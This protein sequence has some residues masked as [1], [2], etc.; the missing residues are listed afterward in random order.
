M[1][2]G[3]GLPEHGA[4]VEDDLDV[5]GR[6]QP[7][8]CARLGFAGRAIARVRM[9]EQALRLG[10]VK[11]E[12]SIGRDL[13]REVGEPAKHAVGLTL[14]VGERAHFARHGRL[15]EGGVELL[16]EPMLH[17]HPRGRARRVD[18]ARRVFLRELLERREQRFGVVLGHVRGGTRASRP[19]PRAALRFAGDEHDRD[20]RRPRLRPQK[21]AELNPRDAGHPQVGHDDVGRHREGELGRQDPVACRA[22]LVA[23]LRQAASQQLSDRVAVVNKKDSHLSLELTTPWRDS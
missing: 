18:R 13:R 12:P 20:V 17:G 19:E 23:A 5:L 16:E 22:D 21:A 11:S 14:R 8:G 3:A 2:A 15:E 6:R 4:L 1:I 9:D 10:D 7:E